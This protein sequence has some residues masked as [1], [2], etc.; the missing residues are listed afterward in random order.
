MN[1]EYIRISSSESSLFASVVLVSSSFE[2]HQ[3]SH[4]TVHAHNF[5]VAFR[6]L[7]HVENSIFSLKADW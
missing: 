1:I 3:L 4:V 6:P 2:S 5:E 7:L